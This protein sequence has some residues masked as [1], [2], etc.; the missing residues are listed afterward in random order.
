[1]EALEGL[2]TG[3]AGALTPTNLVFVFLGVLIGTI[4]GVLPGLGPI[5]AIALLIPLSFGLE[6]TSGLILLSGVYYGAMY[7]G[8]ITSILIRTPGEVAS[9]VTAL[10]GHQMAKNGQAGPALATAAVGS[11]IGGSLAVL[12]LV[13]LSPVLVDLSTSIGA[14]EYAVLLAGALALTTSLMTGSKIKALIAVLVGMC[15]GTIGLDA[16]ESVPRWTFGSIELSDGVDIALLAMAL[17]AVP[18]ALRHLSRGERTTAA[19]IKVQRAWMNKED[20]RRSLGPYARGSVVGFVAGVMPGLGPTLGSFASYSLERRIAKGARRALFGRGAI[21]GVA[22]PETANNAG[23]GGAMVPMLALAIPG[24]A[25]TALLLVVFQMYGLQPGPQLFQNDGPLVWT[26]VASMLVG[27]AMLLV[28]NLPM[29]RLFINLLKVP[30][31]LLYGGVIAF[32]ML[33]AYALTFSFFSL[34]LLVAIGLIGYLM[35]E[36]GFP[37][38]PAILAAVLLPLLELNLRRALLIADG[39]WTVFV[40]RPLSLGI[41]IIIAIGVFAP[42]LLSAARREYAR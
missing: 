8:S 14:A 4:V 26:I 5:T 32:V 1:M 20:L 36:N 35:Q 19:A 42:L 40:D 23:V 3:L 33:G 10:D 18:E 30:P 6:A 41:L 37:L 28:L 17:F 7:G 27:N 29:V 9:A 34:M 15:I 13:F 31:P 25:T 12:G 39:D 38:T 2:L 11:F 21:E 22:G 24:S 16:Q